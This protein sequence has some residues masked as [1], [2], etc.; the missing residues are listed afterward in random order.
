[1]TRHS[2]LLTHGLISFIYVSSNSL[3]LQ[4]RFHSL[5]HTIESLYNVSGCNFYRRWSA[6]KFSLVACTLR[7]PIFFSFKNPLFRYP[8]TQYSW[9][10][11][12]NKNET[13]KWLTFDKHVIDKKHKQ[14]NTFI[15]LFNCYKIYRIVHYCNWCIQ[16]FTIFC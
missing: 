16:P 12:N 3:S 4:Y 7:R 1:M 5:A 14:F 13:N 11:F 8:S 2:Y 15:L 10:K 9:W 6:T